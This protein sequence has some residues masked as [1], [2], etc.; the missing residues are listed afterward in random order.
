MPPGGSAVA[1]G[2]MHVLQTRQHVLV[3]CSNVNACLQFCSRSGHDDSA[4][5]FACASCVHS[6]CWVVPGILR[7]KVKVSVE[8]GVGECIV[9]VGLN[10]LRT[11]WTVSD[12]LPLKITG[13][14]STEQMHSLKADVLSPKSV[15]HIISARQQQ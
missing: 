12:C 7:A 9:T 10:M 2:I 6:L 11:W 8:D 14:V 4:K 13:V 15:L 1:Q 5:P 3:C